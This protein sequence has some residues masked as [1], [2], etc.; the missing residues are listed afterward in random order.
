MVAAA[1]LGC[2]H[3]VVVETCAAV[4]ARPSVSTGLPLLAV[5]FGGLP[6]GRWSGRFGNESEHSE[7]T[8]SRTVVCWSTP[9]R[10][11][12]RWSAGW[13][14][15]ST[16][17]N[18]PSGSS[19]PSDRV[20]TVGGG[21][22]V[23]LLMSSG[24][25][26][27]L[28]EAELRMMLIHGVVHLANGDSQVMGAAL[29][30]VPAADKWIREEPTDSGDRVWNL[31]FKPL[32]R[33][34]RF[35]V[36]VPSRGRE[37]AI[38][39]SGR[40]DRIAGGA[41]GR[42]RTAD[43]GAE[44]TGDRPP[45]ARA[46]DRGRRHPAADGARRLDRAVPDP[47]AGRDAGRTSQIDD[48]I[49]RDGAVTSGSLVT[50]KSYADISNRCAAVENPMTGGIGVVERL[51]GP[52]PESVCPASVF[53]LCVR[54]RENRRRVPVTAAPVSYDDRERTRNSV[55]SHAVG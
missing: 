40:T 9:N 29:G 26:G 11:S 31:V 14:S 33:Y 30:P 41:R 22:D 4:V 24:L 43:R 52:G 17:R 32:R 34:G 7:L 55:L 2:L 53:E 27:V 18:R 8:S 36:A 45:G 19:A 38:G 5:A 13:P 47:L 51:N 35:G 1:V 20:E 37:R 48:R 6:S 15:R 28:P 12:P 21:D 54:S 10:R 25:I 49:C 39:H 50:C 23:V 42:P 3:T 46:L 16:C 44:R